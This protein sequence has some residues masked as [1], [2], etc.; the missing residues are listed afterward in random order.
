MLLCD[1]LKHIFVSLTCDKYSLSL[2]NLV[3]KSL[4]YV[5]CTLD[6]EFDLVMGASDI[7]LF[8]MNCNFCI[9]TYIIY[10]LKAEKYS[11]CC[12][13][14]VFF[15]RASDLIVAED[16]RCILDLKCDFAL[17]YIHL[18]LCKRAH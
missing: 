15:N 13:Q 18:V 9:Y 17:I 10:F 16:T 12:M 3:I 11:S 7:V 8:I 14:P 5:F 1:T 6:L 4:H 2:E